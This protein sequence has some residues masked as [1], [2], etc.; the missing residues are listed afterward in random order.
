[1]KNQLISGIIP[2]MITPLL[3]RNTIDTKGLENLIEHILLGGV[4]GLFILG[5]TGEAP[6]LSYKL[7]EQIIEL[8]CK[9]VN[10]RTPILVGIT[11]TSFTESINLANKAAKHGADA[12][13]LAPPY[14]FPA[15]QQELIEYI[16]HMCQ[17]LPLPLFLYNMPGCTKIN[18]EPATVKKLSEIDKIAGLKDSSGNMT[19]FHKIKSSID[20]QDFKLFVGPEELLAESVLLG[21]DGGVC[22][23]AN[24]FP[25]LYVDLY[26]A[27]INKDLEECIRL[28]KLVIDIS[29]AIYSVGQYGSSYLKGVKSALSV[30]GICND[31]VSEPFH[32]FRCTEKSSIEETLKDLKD[33]SSEYIQW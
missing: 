33:S 21:G 27:A 17:E 23:G 18:L 16:E 26:N 30:M 14:Y 1:M 25:K 19:Y 32:R 29:N 2:P 13:V 8:T 28:H 6:A 5:T 7:R 31:F 9:Q 20:R 4:H 12:V 10:E 11:D 24:M 22:G 3:N 15:G